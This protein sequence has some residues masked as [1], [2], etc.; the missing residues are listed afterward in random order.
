[1]NFVIISFIIILWVY[2]YFSSR[3]K[4]KFI[5]EE[6]FKRGGTN[7]EVDVISFREGI[8]IVKYDKDGHRVNHTVKY[9]GD[10]I[11]E[12]YEENGSNSDNYDREHDNKHDKINKHDEIKNY[13]L[14]VTGLNHITLTVENLNQ[15]I[16]FY[17][18]ALGAKLL[19]RGK[20]LAYFDLAGVWIA[21]NLETNI[22]AEKRERTY[23]HFAFSLDQSGQEQLRERLE[24]LG[25]EYELGRERN[26]R[27]G[28]SIYIRDYDGHLFEFHS[29]TRADRLSYYQDERKDIEVYEIF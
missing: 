20:H 1:M 11:L 17:E 10:K 24:R 5:E 4:E 2:T 19:A 9:L 28:K 8:Y 18:E 14:K 13:G 3:W 29:M 16:K 15:S 23:T 12:W 21:L 27:E 7:A 22:S 6:I 26:P 25:V